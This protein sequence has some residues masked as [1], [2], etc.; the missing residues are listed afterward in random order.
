[1]AELSLGEPGI[2]SF[3][4]LAPLN[5]RCIVCLAEVF[6]TEGLCVGFSPDCLPDEHHAD[7]EVHE[8]ANRTVRHNC[9][10]QI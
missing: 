3:L 7:L 4:P 8:S 6:V 1:M 9:F 5:K 2:P 10:W